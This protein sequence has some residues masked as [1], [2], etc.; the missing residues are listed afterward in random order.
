[1]RECRDIERT[2][3]NDGL[4]DECHAGMNT[5]RI[6]I[7]LGGTKTEIVALRAD[8]TEA[9][10]TRVATPKDD[11]AGT[12]ATIAALVADA[13]RELG[14]R[15]SV[16]IG[17]PGARSLRTG[18]MKNANSTWLNG[19]PL[20][21]DVTRAL[22]R[23]IR[24]TNDANALALSESYDGAA[25]GARVVF[26]VILGTGVGGGIAIESRAYDGANAIAGE[27]GHTP[28]P[29]PN[30]DERPGPACY[31]GRNGC[32][33]TWLCGAAFAAEPDLEQYLDRLARGLAVV[34][35]ILDPGAVVIGG[36]VSNQDAIFECLPS[37]LASHVF[38]DTFDTPILRAKHGDSSGVRGA[39]MLW[40]ERS[41][42]VA[43]DTPA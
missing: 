30:D 32:L 18:L 19:R 8:G 4:S 12:V 7:D 14:T 23:E 42:Q 31:C 9:L 35:D 33:E 39:A 22:Q 27:W 37:L 1:M 36:G 26:G 41:G 10:R 21:D 6:G 38:S 2:L 24:M 40:N 15:A 13:E 28:L 17:T 3:G 5:L 25:A 29:W 11:Y 34:C 43:R 16:G 20:Y